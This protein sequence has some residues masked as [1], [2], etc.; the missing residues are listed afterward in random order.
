[1]IGKGPVSLVRGR[2]SLAMSFSAVRVVTDNAYGAV[3]STRII[4]AETTPAESTSFNPSYTVFSPRPPQAE[5]QA[6]ISNVGVRRAHMAPPPPCDPPIHA[7]D[8]K[9]RRRRERTLRVRSGSRRVQQEA[10]H[11]R[12]SAIREVEGMIVR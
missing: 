12:R 4:L 10:D 6:C 2:Y 9:Q 11:L 7:T 3:C 1:M 5:C 8:A